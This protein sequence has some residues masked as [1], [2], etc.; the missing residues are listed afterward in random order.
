MTCLELFFLGKPS[1]GA[2]DVFESTLV[3]GTRSDAAA[4]GGGRTEVLEGLG[5]AGIEL[6]VGGFKRGG[7]EGLPR[8]TGGGGI[9][10][11]GCGV[12]SGTDVVCASSNGMSSSCSTATSGGETSRRTRVRGVGC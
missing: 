12:R 8:G 9:K 10:I 5:G 6:N 7:L 4:D 3:C 11:E 1:E 2:I